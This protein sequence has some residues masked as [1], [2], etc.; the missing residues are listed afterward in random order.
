MAYKESD[1]VLKVS[2]DVNPSVWDEGFYQVFLDLL[3]KNRDYQK[4]QQR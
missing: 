1:L 4:K 2:K 3:F